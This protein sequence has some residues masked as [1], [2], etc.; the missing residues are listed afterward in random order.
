MTGCSLNAPIEYADGR[1]GAGLAPERA[2]GV[3]PHQA[4][5]QSSLVRAGHE[6]RFGNFGRNSVRHPGGW[7]L[8][9]LLSR[10]FRL[11]PRFELE[12]RIESHELT[13]T[14]H[15]F[16]ANNLNTNVKS[17]LFFHVTSAVPDQRQVRLGARHAFEGS[18]I[19][20]VGQRLSSYVSRR[21]SL[22]LHPASWIRL[23]STAGRHP[24]ACQP[25]NGPNEPDTLVQ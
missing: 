18:T 5:L 23:R 22:R 14:P 1:P 13:N 4:L 8:D 15:F 2:E 21:G 10:T 19:H 3:G 25:G 16:W 12:F 7:N 17:P 6:P 24:M 20:A 9:A 11:R